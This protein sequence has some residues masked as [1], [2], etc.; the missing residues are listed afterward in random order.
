M[1]SSDVRVIS[2]EAI[3]LNVMLNCLMDAK[4]F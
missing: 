3:L 2:V 4:V 1:N